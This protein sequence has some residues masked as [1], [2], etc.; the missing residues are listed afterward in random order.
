MLIQDDQ[1]RGYFLPKGTIVF[2]NTWSIHMD[3]TEYDQPEAF[4][5]ERF[6]CNKFG[7]C[8]SPT[9]E[10]DQRR[11]T[12]S[13]GAGRRVCPGQR[14]AENSL[15]SPSDPNVRG[16]TPSLCLENEVSISETLEANTHASRW[17]TWQRS[18][19]HSI[20]VPNQVIRSIQTSIPASPTVLSSPP[21]LSSPVLRHDPQPTQRSLF[22]SM[23]RRRLYM[24]PTI[25]K[26][27]AINCCFLYSNQHLI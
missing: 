20:S 5:P 22:V 25:A 16:F 24:Q 19:G 26:M 17:S 9:S 12:Y 1:Y 23:T 27:G 15:V 4:I 18:P 6:L 2:A 11:V 10:D 3:E 13:F 14:L 8:K 21:S 7:S